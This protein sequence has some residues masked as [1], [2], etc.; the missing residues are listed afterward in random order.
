MV[1]ALLHGPRYKGGLRRAWR[2]LSHFHLVLRLQRLMPGAVVVFHEGFTHIL[3]SMLIDSKSLRGAWLIRL[4]LSG[5]YSAVGQRGIRFSIDDQ[6][7]ATR[8][9]DRES[10]GRF[11]R[12]SGEEQRRSFAKWLAYHRHVVA[13]MSKRMIVVTIG[14]TAS[15]QEVARVVAAA[16]MDL[17]DNAPGLS[18]PTEAEA[19]AVRVLR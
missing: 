18:A 15:E 4:A 8:V 17:T 16:V 10:L 14:A 11:N 2:S 1:L 6:T 3:W 5:Y 13:L 9:F 19:G 7:A 12:R